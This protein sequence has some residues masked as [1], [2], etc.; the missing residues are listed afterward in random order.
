MNKSI[1]SFTAACGILA[2]GGGLRAQDPV[3]QPGTVSRAEYDKLKTDHEQLKQ[4]MAEM[5]AQMQQLLK[6]RATAAAP[7]DG[8]GIVAPS[9]TARLDELSTEIDT[10]KGR[11][12]ET[13]PGSTK[14]LLAG[15]GTAG[16]TARSGSDPFFTA[17]FNPIF[18]WK[19]SDRLLFEGEIELELEGT[20]THTKLEMAH[21][22]YVLNDYVTL[23]A[24]KFLNPTN[25]FVERQHMSWVNK[26]PDKPLAVYDGLTP[27]ALVGAQVR[28]VIPL[29]PTKLE[30]AAFVANAPSLITSADDLAA[31]GTLEYDN[32]DNQDGHYSFGAHVGF[33]PIP[34]LEIG[35]GFQRFT[36]GP[37]GSAVH[38]LIQSADFSYTRDAAFLKGMVNVRGQWVWS[39]IGGFTYDAEGAD[40]FGPLTFDNKRN[41]GYAQIAYRPT[42]FG[43]DIVKNFETVFRYDVLNQRKTLVGFDEER[44]TIGLNYWLGPSTVF[45]TAYEIDQQNGT[46]HGANAWLLQFA[47]G[48]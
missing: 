17:T 33:I 44:F 9:N 29:G 1:L 18:L 20:E 46:G 24:G 2:V 3:A 34:E 4:Q 37:R 8:K 23:S 26:L 48:F 40:G 28:G 35:Y 6:Q 11:V 16:F 13:F 42:K 43:N 15:Y 5:Q 21:L 45:K 7:S 12:K 22:S 31:L 25:Y 39:S 14:F 32:F 47:T 36:T 38:A 19:M 41:G 30:Y 10:L 27:E